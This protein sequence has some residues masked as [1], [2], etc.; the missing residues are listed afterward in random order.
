MVTINEIITY[1]E[2]TLTDLA[3]R[4]PG[5]ATLYQWLS[6]ETDFF[7][8]PASSKYHSNYDGGLCVHSYLVYKAFEELFPKVVE[9]RNTDVLIICLLHDICKTNFY[10]PYYRNIKEYDQK[11]WPENTNSRSIKYDALGKFIW[12]QEKGYQIDDSFPY[13][14]GEKSVRLIERHLRLP[15]EMAMAIRYHMGAWQETDKPNISKVYEKY[16]L[17]WMLHVADEYSSYILEPNF[18]KQKE[19]V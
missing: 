6:E 7:S 2:S 4:I 8:A 15:D 9:E 17:A 19:E 18:E 10:K 3:N 12:M 13:G 14:H 11:K 5:F 1:V 16:P